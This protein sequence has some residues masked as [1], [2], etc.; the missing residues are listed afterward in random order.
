MFD[1]LSSEVVV[2]QFLTHRFEVKGAFG[3]RFLKLSRW[4]L[5]KLER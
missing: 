1:I 3:L 2:T 5:F 4:E